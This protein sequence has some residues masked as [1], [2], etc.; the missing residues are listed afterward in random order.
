MIVASLLL[1]GKVAFAQQTGL[2]LWLAS[3]LLPSAL[4]KSEVDQRETGERAI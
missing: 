1:P 2:V 3:Y 4:P